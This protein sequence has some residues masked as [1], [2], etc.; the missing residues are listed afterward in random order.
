M[1]Q[2]SIHAIQILCLLA[3][4]AQG[5]VFVLTGTQPARFVT[6]MF[7]ILGAGVVYLAL[8]G[9]DRWVV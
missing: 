2:R 4:M 8:A 5:L 9:V 6:L 3:I 1:L 7:T